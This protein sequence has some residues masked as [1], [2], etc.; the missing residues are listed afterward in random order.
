M[1]TAREH[2]EWSRRCV[3]TTRSGAAPRGSP[4]R[5]TPPGCR[6]WPTTATTEPARSC[7]FRSVVDDSI[8]TPA[9]TGG[10]RSQKLV[11]A[12][13]ARQRG[14]SERANAQLKSWKILREIRCCP[15]QATSLVNVVL[16][17]ILA[18]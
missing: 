16:V 4:T 6:W 13:D 9:A 2:R 11:N 18:S 5:S 3:W 1:P 7:G 14:P 10:S 17:L 15:Y 8:P 12:A